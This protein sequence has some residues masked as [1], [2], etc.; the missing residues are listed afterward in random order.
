MA[1]L[2]FNYKTFDSAD[3]LQ[4]FVTTDPALTRIIAIVLEVSGRFTLFYDTAA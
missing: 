1:L 3:A 4:A 2:T